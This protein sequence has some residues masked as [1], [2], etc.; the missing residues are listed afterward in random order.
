MTLIEVSSSALYQPSVCQQN[1]NWR[2]WISIYG[3]KKMA[4]YAVTLNLKEF[5]SCP[6]ETSVIRFARQS[7]SN[8]DWPIL[9]FLF[10]KSKNWGQL[11]ANT[12]RRDL[13][14]LLRYAHWYSISL[15]RASQLL[16]KRGVSSGTLLIVSHVINT[17]WPSCH[18]EVESAAFA[19]AG[20]TWFSFLTSS[21]HARG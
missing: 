13:L 21:I 20:K 5:K 3:R 4:M 8:D 14:K 10:S 6:I 7:I 1:F 16:L 2:T 17:Q 18:T 9:Q 12:F 19:A 15:L 11:T